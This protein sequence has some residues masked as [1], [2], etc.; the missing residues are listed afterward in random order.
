MSTKYIEISRLKIGDIFYYR[1]TI[2]E[3]VMKDTWTTT[4]KYV[5]DSITP[6]PKYLYCGFSNYTKVEI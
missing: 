4:C 2:Y 3:V 1:N 5:N 6:I